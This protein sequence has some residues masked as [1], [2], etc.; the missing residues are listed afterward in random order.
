MRHLPGAARIGGQDQ[1]GCLNRKRGRLQS[2]PSADLIGNRLYSVLIRLVGDTGKFQ[3]AV[4]NLCL[5]ER[6]HTGKQP[7]IHLWQDHMHRHIGRRQAAFCI[8]PG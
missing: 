6:G 5:L 8:C 3:R 7:S 4:L 2:V 1:S